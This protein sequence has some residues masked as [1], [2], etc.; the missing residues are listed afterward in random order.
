VLP[1]ATVIG[2]TATISYPQQTAGSPWKEEPIGQ[3][4][5]LGYSVEDQEPVGEL[6]ERNARPGDVAA[7]RIRLR[8]RI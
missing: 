5:P 8:R 6:H 1:K 2:A 3:E 4:P 7:E